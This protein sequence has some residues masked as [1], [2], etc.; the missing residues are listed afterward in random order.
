MHTLN[1]HTHLSD[2]LSNNQS[3]TPTPDPNAI[4]EQTL[5]IQDNEHPKVHDGSDSTQS[6]DLYMGWVSL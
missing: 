5:I 2:F 4:M 6:D 3:D 1:S